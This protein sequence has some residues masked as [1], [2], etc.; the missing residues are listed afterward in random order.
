[1]LN[2]KHNQSFLY[3]KIKENENHKKKYSL[4][5]KKL[6]YLTTFNTY[7]NKVVNKKNRKKLKIKQKTLID[8]KFSNKNPVIDRYSVFVEI[9]R[10]T[11]KQASVYKR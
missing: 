8:G 5:K 7:F 1:M 10:H 9:G 4:T 3:R 6:I 11:I 2:H